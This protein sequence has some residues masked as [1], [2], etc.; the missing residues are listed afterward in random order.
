[1][2]SFQMYTNIPAKDIPEGF[3]DEL[4]EAIMFLLQ[5]QKRVSVLLRIEYLQYLINLVN[6]I[7]PNLFTSLY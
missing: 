4:T 5:K 2:P 7:F 6:L 1:M 3:N